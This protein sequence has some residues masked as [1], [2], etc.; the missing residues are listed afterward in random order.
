MPSQISQTNAAT[1]VHELLQLRKWHLTCTPRDLPISSTGI[2]NNIQF[3]YIMSLILNKNL[4]SI[5]FH[6]MN[7]EIYLLK[8]TPLLPQQ[9]R[10][11]N[12]RNNKKRNTEI[13]ANNFRPT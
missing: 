10:V 7:K 1:I 8:V 5:K 4:N 3:T 13:R 6:N 12:K 9:P 11:N 2:Y